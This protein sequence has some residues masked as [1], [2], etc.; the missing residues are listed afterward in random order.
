M[1]AIIWEYAVKPERRGEFE[2]AYAADGPWVELFSQ[3]P[4]FIRTMLLTAPRGRYVTID[5]WTDADSFDAFMRDFAAEYNAMD[6]AFAGMTLE[7][8]KIGRFKRA[9]E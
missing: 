8:T 6:A 3:S 2:R 1:H 4:G 9:S 5:F 7:E